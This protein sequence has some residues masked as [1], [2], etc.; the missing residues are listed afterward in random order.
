VERPLAP[1]AGGDGRGAP[2]RTGGLFSRD[3]AV[4]RQPPEWHRQQGRRPP[5]YLS[6]SSS[7]AW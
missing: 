4:R 7:R 6:S 1:S 2:G 3:P 5:D